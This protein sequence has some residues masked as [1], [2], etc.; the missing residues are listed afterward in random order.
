MILILMFWIDEKIMR[1][2]FKGPFSDLKHEGPFLGLKKFLTT[3]T[4]L[5]MMNNAFCFLLKAL[6][7]H[8]IFTFSEYLVM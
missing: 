6:F 8:K 4:P 5:I 3:E 2:C 7:L 1:K